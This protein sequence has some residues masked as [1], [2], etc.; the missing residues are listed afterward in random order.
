M[1]LLDRFYR[2]NEITF[3]IIWIVAYIVIASL[4]DSASRELGIQKCV[5]APALAIMSIILWAW[6]SHAGLKQ[7]YGLRAPITP[8][9]RM[10]LYLPLLI[11]AFYRFFFGAAMNYSSLETALF[12]VS[13]LCVGFLEEMIFRGLLFRGM[14]KDNTTAAIIVSAITFGIGHIVNVFN[15]SGQDLIETLVQIAFAIIIGFVLVFVLLKSG[16]IWP[17]IIFHG[18]YNS[19]SA[20]S[21]EAAAIAMLGSE[22]NVILFVLGLAIVVGGG[23]LIYL[24]KL[25]SVKD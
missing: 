15:A 11:I 12:I 22:L 17:C 23:Y 4:A 25:P 5:T 16:S 24:A 1:N 18:I 8:A 10:L 14:A 6:V 7:K 3:A 21:D 13:M 20:F 9:T 19:L 2:R